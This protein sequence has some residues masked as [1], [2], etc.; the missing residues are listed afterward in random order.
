MRI[1]VTFRGDQLLVPCGGEETIR[2]LRDQVELRWARLKRREAE[3]DGDLSGEASLAEAKK[4][5]A[6][7]TRDGFDLDDDDLIMDSL[8]DG[9]KVVAVAQGEDA[10][11]DDED[12]GAA[13]TAEVDDLVSK[14]A[15]AR[16][17]FAGAGIGVEV[18]QMVVPSDADD[19]TG[20]SEEKVPEGFCV[21]YRFAQDGRTHRLAVSEEMTWLDV[22][23]AIVSRE[24]DDVEAAQMTMVLY[25]STGM[26]L[27]ESDKELVK[28][29]RSPEFGLKEDELIHTVMVTR[30]EDAEA[31][32]A[33]GGPA[34][35]PP[36]DPNDG[37]TQ[38]FVKSI[39][40]RTL[41]VW[42]NAEADRV[43][44][45][46]RKAH[47]KAAVTRGDIAVPVSVQVLTHGRA[48]NNNDLLSEHGVTKDS[49]VHMSI[50]LRGH[51]APAIGATVGGF[52]ANCYAG[53]FKPTIPQT[54]AASAA[55]FSTLYM[56]A[57][58]LNREL[59]GGKDTHNKVLRQL[60]EYTENAPLVTALKELIMR[61]T[62][63]LEH[64]IALVEGLLRLW[65]QIVPEAVAGTVPTGVNVDDDHLGN[66]S[67]AC[68]AF[69]FDR[70]LANTFD[71]PELFET[72][73]LTCPLSHEKL[74]DPVRIPGLS[75][76]VNRAS[77]AA[78]REENK[79][80][81]GCTKWPL[82][83]EDITVHEEVALLLVR[84]PKSLKDVDRLSPEALKKAQ[85]AADAA[86]DVA[87]AAKK[88]VEGD[89]GDDEGE[90]AGHAAATGKRGGGG[91]G[92]TA[93]DAVDRTD[94]G[95]RG[96][97]PE[98]LIEKWGT[99]DDRPDSD[100]KVPFL[101][102]LPTLR[103]REPSAPMPALT[104]NRL[105]RLC[106]FQQ[107]AAGGC[108]MSPDEVEI[109]DPVAGRQDRESV[110]TLAAFLGGAEAGSD[111]AEDAPAHGVLP[112]SEGVITDRP[113]EA[114]VTLLDVSGSMQLDAFPED[115]DVQPPPPPGHV[116]LNIASR[117]N[118]FTTEIEETKTVAELKAALE[119]D[120]GIPRH[121]AL[122]AFPPGTE[123]ERGRTIASY[124]TTEPPYS[125]AN[126]NIYADTDR[127]QKAAPVMTRLDAV[128]QLFHAFANRAMAY[129]LKT[130]IGLTTFN[131]E[132]HRA[133]E[134]TELFVNF[135]RHVDATRSDGQ[136]ALWDALSAAADE[137]EDIG[138]LY[139]GCKLRIMCL[140]DGLDTSSSARVE[141]VASRLQRA[142]IVVDSVLIG[143]ETNKVLKSVSVATG[144]CCWKPETITEGLALFEVET[145]ISL[146]ERA[147]VRP[148]PAVDAGED[149]V[150][151]P[152]EDETA[153]PY[154]S[155]VPAHREPEELKD[156][157]VSAR[158]MVD[159]KPPEAATKRLS[160]RQATRV[161]REMANYTKDPHPSI[162]IYPCSDN[163]AFWRVLIQGPS[164][165][166][167]EGGTW[168][169]WLLFPPSYPMSPPEVR[170]VTKI[171]HANINASGKVCHAAFGRDYTSDMSIKMILSVCY[172]LLLTPEP[173]DPLD[174]GKAEAFFADRERY[175]AKAREAT[176]R[177]AS[178]TLEEWRIEMVGEE[179]AAEIA[180]E[181][182]ALA[183]AAD[184]SGGLSAA[185]EV[186]AAARTATRAG[187]AGG[188]VGAAGAR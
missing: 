65:R 162:E 80:P 120:F 108:G 133:C 50:G 160:G 29:A 92:G 185:A 121:T 153:F 40:G 94:L 147:P 142:G 3:K 24:C 95:P 127:G 141:E 139:E 131:H 54:D 55:F 23:Q 107:R 83:D 72:V 22:T 126:V 93:V 109:F 75:G 37:D 39:T 34:G 188:P 169:A 164:G 56:V 112:P 51:P 60:F 177:Y 124:T 62:L 161:M 67:R 149:G 46:K 96:L 151:S 179:E 26:P 102:I 2:W 175:E 90:S 103:M 38:I 181:S 146:L 130:V 63:R 178:K 180:A 148:Q 114:I 173:D 134:L 5:V 18:G 145:V 66:H 144:G 166:P 116:R 167:Y 113:R 78:A 68:W 44:D 168:L 59:M 16:A 91:G 28:V 136:T 6:I 154:S 25:D 82:A 128:K 4:V 76:A 89:E 42:I 159:E 156:A 69:V 158:R 119:E 165:T 32:G 104:T 184:E 118:N 36:A 137:L 64:K 171:H 129:Q 10:P 81:D 71:C 1:K 20:S 27:L 117:A 111:D 123:L 30:H 155:Q 70:A 186:A 12:A 33:D 187:G 73:S 87:A 84:S 13:G 8:E 9:S 86:A 7:R 140:T 19:P 125:L 35:M 135:Q 132:V 15:L 45:L 172:G 43:F 47:A 52:S 170:L 150:L 97:L 49:T 48:M 106:V 74:V 174:S 152:F 163:I 100:A 41:T 21:R 143:D 88:E 77:V 58:H 85:A 122:Y 99:F 110:N 115:A 31:V 14:A 105:K 53:S 183:S 79:K 98:N 101:R 182:R 176:A 17:A 138:E 11:M 61:R 57:T 157:V